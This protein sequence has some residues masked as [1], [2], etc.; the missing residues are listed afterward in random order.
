MAGREW[1]PV[2]MLAAWLLGSFCAAAEGPQPPVEALP[3]EVPGEAAGW[4][5]EARCDA[6]ACLPVLHPPGTGRAEILL[7]VVPEDRP[8]AVDGVALH[9]L[10]VVDL[11]GDGR[12]EVKVEWRATGTPRPA[13]G[14]WYRELTTVV[15][16]QT[17]LVRMHVETGAFGGASETHCEGTLTFQPTGAILEQHCQLRACLVG[18][19]RPGEC[20][21]GPEHRTRAVVYSEGSPGQ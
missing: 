13:L 9:A 2:T 20:A 12:A 16:G 4:R 1:A 17:G 15:D 8:W 18:G 19:A 21:G 3:A 7:P 11:D 5:L 14:S 10:S 6:E